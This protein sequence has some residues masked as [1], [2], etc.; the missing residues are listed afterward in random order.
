LGSESAAVQAAVRQLGDFAYSLRPPEP[1]SR[2]GELVHRALLDTCGVIV[3]GAG[4]AEL[5]ALLA[6]WAPPPGPAQLLCA[7]RTAPVEVAAHLNGVAAVCLELDEG[8]KYARG[9]PAAHVLPATLAVAQQLRAPGPELV[10]AFLAGH[11][12][13]SRFGRATRLSPGIHPHGNWAVAGAA[14]AAG[15]LLGLDAPA[16]AA[17]IDAAGAMAM[18]TP[19]PPVLMGDQVRNQWVGAAAVSGIAAARLAAAGLAS[20]SGSAAWSLGQALGE[21]DPGQLTDQLGSRYDIG[22]GYYKRHASCSY[23]HPAADALLALL[24]AHPE[25]RAGVV[26]EV[27]VQTYPAAAKLNGSGSDNRLAAMFS[28]PHVIGAV[29][30]EGHAGPSSFEAGVRHSPEVRRLAEATTVQTTAEFTDRLPEERGARVTLT[31]FD[32]ECLCS[33]VP[34]PVG[35]VAYHPFGLDEVRTKLES[36]LPIG[37]S[38]ADFEAAVRRLAS[39]GDANDAL[40][41]MP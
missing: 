38:V 16:L 1:G 9:H 15:R 21:F 32:G 7:G 26:R 37:T 22:N 34:N 33:E 14:A 17:A 30:S 12:V 10:A 11:E 8:N 41:E 4:T 19:W 39:A 13:A 23:T 24:A 18:V 29:L 28:I 3:A 40:R 31:L 36:L 35:D 20:V 25:L 5:R 6:V 27:L 2:L